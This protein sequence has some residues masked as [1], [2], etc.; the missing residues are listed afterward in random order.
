MKIEETFT[1]TSVP[2][3]HEAPEV[4]HRNDP[5]SAQYLGL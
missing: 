3:L 2:K 4:Y 1:S 5:S